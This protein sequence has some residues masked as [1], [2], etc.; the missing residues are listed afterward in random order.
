MRLSL[1]WRGGRRV[2]VVFGAAV[3]SALWA[4]CV[5]A[6]LLFSISEFWSLARVFDAARIGAWLAF[7]L[8]LLGEW[9][10]LPA[11]TSKLSARFWRVVGTVVLL[12]V[13]VILPEDLPWHDVTK[14]RVTTGVFL[15]LLGIS[16]L[17]LALTEQL[18][19]RTPENRQ[20]AIKPL[21]IGIAG[22]FAFDLIMYAEA[23]LFKHLD[24]GM[25]AAR[26][27]AHAFV[28]FFVAV[29]T[30]LMQDGTHDK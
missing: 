30:A 27:V 17:G 8:L 29:A 1:N 18:Y 9:P 23:V 10:E 16:V 14:E 6:A 11:S 26:G 3:A 7:L 22:M 20:W 2:Y 28:V 24:P 13:A 19:R 15:I 25:W 4:G 5:F 12:V 21:L